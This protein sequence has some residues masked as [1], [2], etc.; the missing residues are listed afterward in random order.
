M[1]SNEDFKNDNSEEQEKDCLKKS[2]DNYMAEGIIYGVLA[3]I[4]I[5]GLFDDMGISMGSALP[6]GLVVGMV[7]GMSIKKKKKP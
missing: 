2:D 4:V 5:G 6:I 1:D 3:G 7:V